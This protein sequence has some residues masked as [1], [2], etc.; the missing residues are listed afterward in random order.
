MY[1]FCKKTVHQIGLM[2]LFPKS[3]LGFAY[4]YM[5]FSITY[6]LVR[7]PAVLKKHKIETSNCIFLNEEKHY[8]KLLKAEVIPLSILSG[9]SGIYLFPYFLFK[10][11]RDFEIYNCNL[12]KNDYIGRCDYLH[13]NFAEF[14]FV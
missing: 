6:S 10:D 7:K 12:R 4:G 11:L 5:F 8:R 14:L 2:K 13:N 1:Y 9:I 3:T